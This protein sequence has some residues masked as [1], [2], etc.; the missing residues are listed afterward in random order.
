MRFPPYAEPPKVGV[1]RA[2]RQLHWEDRAWPVLFAVGALARA[3]ESFGGP[4]ESLWFL[5][6]APFL[7]AV[8]FWRWRTGGRS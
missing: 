8:T 4:V 6:P 7:A 2:R 1:R 5:V 3:V